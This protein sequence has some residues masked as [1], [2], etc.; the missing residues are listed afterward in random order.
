MIW[1]MKRKTNDLAHAQRG[2]SLIEVVAAI[3]VVGI[4]ITLFTKVQRMTSRTSST[5]SK[6]LLAGKMIEQHLEDMRILIARDTLRN[7]PPVDL[8]ISP[9]APNNITLVRDISPALS[10]KD[11]A[12]VN[13]VV[14]VDIK[15]SWTAPYPD[16]LKVTTYVSKRF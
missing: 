5:N 2:W 4:G 14:Q 6:I 10:P 3:V 16:S 1:K 15:T 9:S 12:V 7:F 8:T 11:G 13:N